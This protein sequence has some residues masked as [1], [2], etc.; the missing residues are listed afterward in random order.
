ML[1]EI[2]HQEIT[3]EQLMSWTIYLG[4][5]VLPRFGGTIEYIG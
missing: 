5:S 4:M 1:K 3:G 2:A